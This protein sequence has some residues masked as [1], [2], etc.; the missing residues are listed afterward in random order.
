[1]CKFGGKDG[2][3]LS[4]M[5]PGPTSFL[6][7]LQ[8]LQDSV[9]KVLGVNQ[10][11]PQRLDVVELV[12]DDTTDSA[13]GVLPQHVCD[14]TDNAGDHWE[15]SKNAYNASVIQKAQ[16]VVARYQEHNWQLCLFFPSFL[17]H[18]WIS[19]LDVNFC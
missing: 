2:M 14:C 16:V 11:S 12:D 15:C 17:V 13:T 6:K 8:A 5:I 19:L 4:T 7:P 9:V 10:K 18:S 1:M 3:S